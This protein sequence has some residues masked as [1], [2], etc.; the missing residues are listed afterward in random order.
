LNNDGKQYPHL[1]SDAYADFIV[2]IVKPY[3]DAHYN[4]AADRAHTGIGGSSMGG[5]MSFY[6]GLKYPKV[7]GKVLAFSPSFVLYREKNYLAALAKHDFSKKDAAPRLYLYAGGDGYGRQSEAGIAASLPALVKT[8][9]K[10]KFPPA[11]ITSLTWSWAK[12]NDGSWAAA[13]PDAFEWLFYP[14]KAGK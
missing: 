5:I 7:F 3:I 4:S 1:V 6:M 12:H 2:K 14:P 13:F 9:K 10:A 11:K 8:L